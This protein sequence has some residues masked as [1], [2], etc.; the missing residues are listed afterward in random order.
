M[1]GLDNSTWQNRVVVG[2]HLW[3]ISYM[4]EMSM[5]VACLYLTI[6]KWHKEAILLSSMTY[7]SFFSLNNDDLGQETSNNFP[8]KFV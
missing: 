1:K 3:V 2:F 4:D 6:N 5:L 7:L 8:A